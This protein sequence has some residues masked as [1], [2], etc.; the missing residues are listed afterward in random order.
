MLDVKMGEGAVRR[1]VFSGTV[2][3]I[4]ADVSMEISLIYGAL[5]KHSA[6]EAELFKGC[7]EMLVKDS[8]M[9]DFIFSS[10]CH[11]SLIKDGAD[12]NAITINKDE[13]LRQ[14]GGDWK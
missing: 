11:D 7:I 6:K 5:L 2:D 1:A 14:M 9:S 13:L 8:R 4:A 10:R 12:F 3:E